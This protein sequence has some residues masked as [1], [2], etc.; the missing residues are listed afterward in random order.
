MNDNDNQRTAT[1]NNSNKKYYTRK[2]METAQTITKY[3]SIQHQQLKVLIS[4]D[5]LNTDKTI[6]MVSIN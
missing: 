5:Y 4:N 1:T 6:S 2:Q 3:C